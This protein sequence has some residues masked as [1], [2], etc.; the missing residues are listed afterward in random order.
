MKKNALTIRGRNNEI[1]HRVTE[2]TEPRRKPDDEYQGRDAGK[3]LVLCALVT[4]W[5]KNF[6]PSLLQPFT[7]FSNLLKGKN[8]SNFLCVA[9]RNPVLPQSR[10]GRRGGHDAAHA[11]GAAL[12][13][14]ICGDQGTRLRHKASAGQADAQEHT[15][16]VRCPY[17]TD[18]V[19]GEPCPTFN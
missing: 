12:P 11:C 8:I 19:L 18:G 15:R 6:P 2:G 7:T 1:G 5:F 13:S 16:V 17:L 14:L 4:W 3:M 10:R 9:A